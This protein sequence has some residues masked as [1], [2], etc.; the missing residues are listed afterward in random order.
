MVLLLKFLVGKFI[1]VY[2]MVML[3]DLKRIKIYLNWNLGRYKLFWIKE[4]IMFLDR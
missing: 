1:I 4:K 3:R 2:V